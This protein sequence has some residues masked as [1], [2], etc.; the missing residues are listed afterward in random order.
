MENH[1]KIVI[2][3]QWSYLWKHIERYHRHQKQKN[4]IIKQKH[5]LNRF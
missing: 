4:N 2:A 3:V 5:R 1:Q